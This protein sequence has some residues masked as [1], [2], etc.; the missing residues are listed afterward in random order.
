MTMR[1]L[2]EHEKEFVRRSTEESG[3]TVEGDETLSVRTKSDRR[4]E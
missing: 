2:S 1:E 4:R 3:A